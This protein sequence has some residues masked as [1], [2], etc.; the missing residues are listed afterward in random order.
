MRTV[1][2]LVDAAE[3]IENAS[4]FYEA[5]ESGYLPSWTCGRTQIGSTPN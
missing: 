4:G 3:D 2:V 5:Q 1:V